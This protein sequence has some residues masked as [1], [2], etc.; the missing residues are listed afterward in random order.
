MCLC[1]C[2]PV[3]ACVLLAAEC[4]A[5]AAA[6]AAG[7]QNK[8]AVLLFNR[9][10]WRPPW[11]APTLTACPRAAAGSVCTLPADDRFF[12]KLFSVND[13]I[14]RAGFG[15]SLASGAAAAAAADDELTS[16]KTKHKKLYLMVPI[17]SIG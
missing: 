13:I 12:K 14:I 1:V 6:A 9:I 15:P 8:S 5:A 16:K 11:R 7:P 2:V 3:L 17:T 4:R 10:C